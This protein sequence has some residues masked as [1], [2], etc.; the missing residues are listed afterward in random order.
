MD[1]D[2]SLGKTA[3]WYCNAFYMFL[4][5]SPVSLLWKEWQSWFV[6]NI[7]FWVT[8]LAFSIS[9][10][11]FLRFY[12]F[13]FRE[14]GREGEREGE[15]HWCAR[16]TLI[17]CLLHTSNWRSGPQLRHVPW[18]GIEPVTF[19]SQSGAQ[20]TEPHQPGLFLWLFYGT[21]SLWTSFERGKRVNASSPICPSS[22]KCPWD[23]V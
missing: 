11:F 23:P 15:K 18:L 16:E 22:T 12:L 21:F 8:P 13:I 17:G 5:F 7:S 6:Q 2:T 9:L 3:V 19:A 1:T 4:H 14:R 20:S 10:T